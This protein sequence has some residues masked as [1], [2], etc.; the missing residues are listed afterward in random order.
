MSVATTIFSGCSFT[1]GE[2][3]AETYNSQDL[4][5]NILH[6]TNEH[7]K[8]TQ[9]KNIGVSGSSNQRIFSDTVS[10]ILNS[11]NVKFVFVAWTS[12]P[13]YQIDL[14]TET[15]TTN[16]SVSAGAEYRDVNTHTT[17]YSKQYL[18]KTCN[19]FLALDTDHNQILQLLKLTNTLITLSKKLNFK[20]FFIN[21]LC[22]WDQDYFTKLSNVLPNSYTPYT[23]H[24]L[25]TQTR[26]DEEVFSLYNKI[27]SEYAQTGG[28]QENY[29]L[30]LYKSLISIQTDYNS[31]N[32][33]PGIE[34]NLTY[35]KL[36][37]KALNNHLTDTV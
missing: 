22:P 20:I 26:S 4:W 13:R 28:I 8:T 31:D 27:H 3:F 2:G 33:H 6:R 24:L 37:S 23:Q 25:N 5:V 14:G 1:Y 18:E 29:W 36:L 32:N 34:S 17:K 10:A 12:V 7:L 16:I 15:Y 9:I 21:G 30:N 11:T 19:R 35:A